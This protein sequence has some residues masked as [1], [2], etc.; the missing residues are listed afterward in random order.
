[1]SEFTGYAPGTPSWVDLASTDIPASI[2]FYGGLFGWEAADQGPE[3]GGYHMFLKHGKAVAGLGPQFAEGAP[4]NWATYVSVADV[5]AAVASVRDGG[6]AVFVEPM[7]VLD[8]GRMA[9]CADPTGAGFSLWQPGTHAGAQLANEPG[10]FCWN[11]LNTRDPETAAAFYGAVLGWKGKTAETEFPYTE[12]QLDGKSVAGMVD[13]TDRVP[14]DVPAHWLTYFGVESCDEAVATV[15]ELGGGALVGP[16]DLPGVGRIAVVNDPQGAF[17]A[18][19][20]FPSP[21]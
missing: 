12:L 8:A 17:F 7:D 2:A 1:M 21:G 14:A 4:P 11:E 6:G 10:T 5:D 18:V 16:L 13:I 20:E 3:A 9:V 19:F 15:Q